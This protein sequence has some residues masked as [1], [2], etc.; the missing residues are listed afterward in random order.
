MTNK[1]FIFPQVQIILISCHLLWP[2]FPLVSLSHKIRYFCNWSCTPCFFRMNMKHHFSFVWSHSAGLSA[3]S[4]VCADLTCGKQHMRVQPYCT[5]G[6]QTDCFAIGLVK[7]KFVFFSTLRCIFKA[8]LLRNDRVHMHCRAE[9]KRCFLAF[10]WTAVLP[11]E[12][13]NIFFFLS[14]TSASSTPTPN[15]LFL[16]PK[17]CF[18]FYDAA[19]CLAFTLSS[20]A[21]PIF[22]NLRQ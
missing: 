11:E 22:C 7:Q 8:F 2:C 21:C 13:S 9:D 5:Q 20:T 15:L 16:H 1:S 19:V 17:G 18:Y 14:Q 3:M 10:L 12:N 4:A 6:K